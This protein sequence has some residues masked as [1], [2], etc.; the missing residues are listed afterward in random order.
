MLEPPTSPAQPDKQLGV[1]A[2][3]RDANPKRIA[4][5]VPLTREALSALVTSGLAVIGDHTYGVPHVPIYAGTARLIIGRY[6]SIADQVTIVLG[7]EHRSE[8]TTTYP[9][10]DLDGWG[11]RHIPGHPTTKGDVII[12]ND[13]WIGLG[14]T[15]LSGITVGDGAILG[16]RSVIARSVEP[17]AIV[18]GNPGRHLRF[19]FEAATIKRL[20]RLRWWNWSDAKVQRWLPRMLSS[21]VSG[22]LQAAE[23]SNAD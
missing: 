18:A 20:L 22:F 11:A 10:S 17:Y 6:C 23:Q 15:I 1:S 13:V 14:C 16:A 21:D 9:F 8:W 5:N 4:S 12:G 2:E 19:R 7:G 3:G